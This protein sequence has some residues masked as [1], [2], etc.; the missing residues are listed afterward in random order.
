M[1]VGQAAGHAALRAGHSEMAT[2]FPTLEMMDDVHKAIAEFQRDTDVAYLVICGGC[3][4]CVA[5]RAGPGLV[6]AA[7]LA[8]RRRPRGQCASRCSPLTLRA[9]IRRRTRVLHAVRIRNA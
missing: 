2:Y 6:R 1:S 7:C 8:S 3:P 5:A 4:R 9:A